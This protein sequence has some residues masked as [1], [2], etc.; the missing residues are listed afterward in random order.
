[1]PEHSRETQVGKRIGPSIFPLGVKM[2]IA[3]LCMSR[4]NSESPH[5]SCDEDCGLL[6][7]CKDSGPK[8][9]YR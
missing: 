6:K 4:S 5:S 3:A 1:M 7:Q 9:T 2:A 8:V